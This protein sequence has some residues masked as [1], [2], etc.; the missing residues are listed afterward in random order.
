MSPP[1][2]RKFLKRAGVVA[3]VTGGVAAGGAAAS[4]GTAS[5]RAAIG[6]STAQEDL[7]SLRGPYADE[8]W[9]GYR[10]G[11]G[12]LGVVDAGPAVD[13]D[14]PDCELFYDGPFSGEPAI[15]DGTLYIADGEGH[16]VALDAETADLVWTSEAGVTGRHPSVAY[17]RVITTGEGAVLA[18]DVADGSVDWETDLDAEVQQPT[19]GYEAVFVVAGGDLHAL[20]VQDGSTQWTRTDE[21]FRGSPSGPAVG[22]DQVYVVVENDDSSNDRDLVSLDAASGTER[23]RTD[24]S[25]YVGYGPTAATEF[26]TASRGMD[27]RNVYEADTGEYHATYGGESTPAHDDQVYTW[28]TDYRLKTSFFDDNEGW[29][30]LAGSLSISSP[31]VAGDLV[32][33]YFGR[34]E[35]QDRA[36]Y[37]HSLLAFDKYS[38]EIE[39]SCE[40]QAVDEPYGSVSI[41]ATSEAVYVLGGDEIHVLRG[42]PGGN[43]EPTPTEEEPTPTEEEPTPTEE[44][45][46]PTESEPTPT[47]AEP[48]PTESGPTPTEDQP[49]PTDSQPTPTEGGGCPTST[50]GSGSCSPDDPTPT[51]GAT[52]TETVG[53]TPTDHDSAVVT[54]SP[55]N[56]TDEVTADGPGLGIVSTITAIGGLGYALRRRL[57]EPAPDEDEREP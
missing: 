26:V 54:A 27:E 25:S 48:T 41:V 13:P 14:A 51:D 17:Q 22:N 50:E 31:T 7:P 46:T 39:W 43:P 10:G 19:V 37:E 35:D 20:D 40:T 55:T 45:P 9:V 56:G 29:E 4:D 49:T 57:G 12:R 47:E 53:P 44:E 18:L 1:S 23:W 36:E 6:V 32:Y 34:A 38:G 3:G 28:N 52:V 8:D 42:E 33:A 2:R 30:F 16:V 5:W 21:T 24:P 15:A 11:P